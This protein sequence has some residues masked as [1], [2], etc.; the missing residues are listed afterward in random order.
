MCEVI[1][2]GVRVLT[3]ALEEASIGWHSCV[4][5][6]TMYCVRHTC[7]CVYVCMYVCIRIY[8]YI[9]MCMYMYTHCIVRLNHI[10]Q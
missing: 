9:Y 1:E 8:M 2:L 10:K 6:A 4:A 5:N 3:G 7:T